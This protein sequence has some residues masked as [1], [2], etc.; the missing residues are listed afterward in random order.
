MG[1]FTYPEYG[2]WEGKTY[3]TRHGSPFD[4]GSADSYYGRPMNPHYFAG[5][6][7]MSEE[8]SKKEM[9]EQQ[10]EAYRAGY[11]WNELCGDK[12]EY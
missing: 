10:I 11:K 1:C 9:T 4:R 6:T 7:H 8:F 5:D 3:A 2:T 12:K